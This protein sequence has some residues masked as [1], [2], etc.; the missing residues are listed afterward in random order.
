MTKWH[1]ISTELFRAYIYSDNS[2]LI[3]DRPL[4]LAVKRGPGGRDSHRLVAETAGGQKRAYYVAPGWRAI[5]WAVKE[6]EPMFV[7]T[8]VE[9]PIT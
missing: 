9:G 8:L 3:I 5:E 2:K 4:S 7:E 1:D 6:G